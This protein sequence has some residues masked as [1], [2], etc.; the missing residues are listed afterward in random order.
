M[1]VLTTHWQKMNPKKW[2]VNIVLS[3][4]F[5]ECVQL[6]N[7]WTLAAFL[8]LLVTLLSSHRQQQLKVN[9]NSFSIYNAGI[10]H[11][12]KVSL[13]SSSS[14][15]EC[16]QQKRNGHCCLDG[17]HKLVYSILECSQGRVYASKSFR[18]FKCAEFTAAVLV[19]ESK[20]SSINH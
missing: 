16:S 20:H 1:T 18:G 15:K 6:M 11:V 5:Y 8:T 12:T 19:M 14:G 2:T 17:I 13:F 10:R 3:N 4:N 9:I 7:I